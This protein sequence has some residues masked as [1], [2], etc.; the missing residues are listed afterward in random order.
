MKKEK[1]ITILHCV[2]VYPA[3][4]ENVNMNIMITLRDKYGFP[5]GFSDHTTNDKSSIIAVAM[6]AN[7]IEKHVTL[8][9]NMNGPDHHMSASINELSSLIESIRNV[10]KVKGS[11]SK[12]LSSD[13]IEIAKVARKSIVT[14]KKMLPG[15]KIKLKHICYKRPGT[16]FLP[17][18]QDR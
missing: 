10:E 3:I 2:S 12:K 18:E 7:V 16:G 8:D 11:F 5:V 15:E 1:D 14:K 6:G 13:E 17:T 9:K 4:E